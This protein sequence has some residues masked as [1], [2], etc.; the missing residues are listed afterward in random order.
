VTARQGEAGTDPVALDALRGAALAMLRPSAL[1]PQAVAVLVR[2]HLPDAGAALSKSCARVT[3]GNPFQL[4]ALLDDAREAGINRRRGSRDAITE[5][6]PTAVIERVTEQLVALAPAA[7]AIAMALAVLDERVALDRVAAT[8]QLRPDQA[9]RGAEALAAVHLTAPDSPLTFVSPLVGAAVRASIPH[10]EL[11]LLQ[12]RAA[13]DAMPTASR[14]PSAEAELGSAALP[15]AP[16]RS[17]LQADALEHVLEVVG[18]AAPPAGGPVST[19]AAADAAHC[20]AWGLYHQGEITESVSAAQTALDT[21]ALWTRSA[22]HGVRGAL[23]LAHIEQGR[24][25]Q[26]SPA[27]GLLDEAA[28]V[29][30]EDLPLLLDT[31]AQLR[32]AQKRPGEALVDALEAG[33]RLQTVP[34][35]SHPGIVAWRSTAALARL[36]LDEPRGARELAEEELELARAAGLTRVTL[37]CLRVLGQALT[38]RRRLELLA[39]AVALGTEAPVRLEYLRALVDLGA[40]TRRANRRMAAR[41]HLDQALALCHARG[42]TALAQRAK[43]E[44]AAGGGRRRRPRVTGVGALTP[45]ERRVAALAAKGHTTREIAA[46][47]FVTPKA[48]EF[49]LRHVYRKLEI[50]STRADLTRALQSPSAAE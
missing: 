18:E 3:A 47:L 20:R 30:D 41:D 12:Q 42:A 11:E 50:P 36:A 6:V 8:A 13:V 17:L 21:P 1:S 5:I 32:L 4:M 16:T 40:A 31:R 43:S 2:A 37:R 48:V 35:G 38:G 46:E 19:G 10:L 23:A 25:D 9:A 28:A 22:P 27:L 44:I 24:I 26:A 45:S 34:G 7:Q 14:S 15:V 39:E 49:H 29:A 33:R